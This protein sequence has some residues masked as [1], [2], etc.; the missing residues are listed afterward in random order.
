VQEGPG[1]L[2]PG[3]GTGPV[4]PQVALFGG[5]RGR[6]APLTSLG[7]GCR[8]RPDA[9]TLAKKSARI[10]MGR[11]ALS[12]GPHCKPA[13]FAVRPS[14]VRSSGERWPALVLDEGPARSFPEPRRWKVY[15][16][17]SRHST[18]LPSGSPVGVDRLEPLPL[19]ARSRLSPART[20]KPRPRA[21]GVRLDGG[22]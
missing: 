22:K 15:S 21:E 20:S 3:C 10:G 18:N 19:S 6:H 16:S 11:P 14:P 7:A 1:A 13:G 9:S 5:L 8:R 4:P 2:L 17:I 12:A